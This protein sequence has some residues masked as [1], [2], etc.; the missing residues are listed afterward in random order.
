M[1]KKLLCVLLLVSIVVFVVGLLLPGY[2]VDGTFSYDALKIF[3][4]SISGNSESIMFD[5]SMIRVLQLYLTNFDFDSTQ[6]IIFVRQSPNPGEWLYTDI[7]IQTISQDGSTENLN[8]LHGLHLS[9]DSYKGLISVL[10][11]LDHEPVNGNILTT[12]FLV[13]KTFVGFL[14]AFCFILVYMLLDILSMIWSIL[15][16]FMRLFGWVT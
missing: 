5:V 7:I 11:W 6:K 4:E 3:I 10:G 9:V 12:V 2:S 8:V 1:A 16:G 13:V 15:Y 14:V